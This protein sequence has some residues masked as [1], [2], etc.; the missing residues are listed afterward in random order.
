MLSPDACA[1]KAGARPARKT[2]CVSKIS[3]AELLYNILKL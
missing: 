3:A 1:S 2:L